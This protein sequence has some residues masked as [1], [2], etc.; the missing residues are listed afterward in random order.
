MIS[1]DHELTVPGRPNHHHLSNTSSLKSTTTSSSKRTS[2]TMISHPIQTGFPGSSTSANPGHRSFAPPGRTHI[3]NSPNGN[4]ATRPFAFAE[5]LSIHV[6]NMSIQTI[7]NSGDVSHGSEAASA[8]FSST[9]KH[10]NQLD[11]A[12]M[13]DN[14]A[15]SRFPTAESVTLTRNSVPMVSRNAPG[16]QSTFTHPPAINMNQYTGYSSHNP[17]GLHSSQYRTTVTGDN[18]PPSNSLQV[19][20]HYP[21]IRLTISLTTM[22]TSFATIHT[23]H[24]SCAPQLLP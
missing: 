13:I 12:M 15:R 19:Y 11:G 4:T 14:A 17:P 10:H 16:P 1:P 9:Y 22:Q 7:V 8:H 3:V 23:Q 5:D 6:A 2:R 24:R 21:R 18:F 20:V